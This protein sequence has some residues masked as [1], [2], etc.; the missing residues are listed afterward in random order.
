[1]ITDFEYQAL[2]DKTG[3]IPLYSV[4]GACGYFGA[5]QYVENEG[6][7]DA[8]DVIKF[9]DS[10]KHFVVH[11]SGNSMLPQIKDGNLCIFESYRG[12]DLH[13]INRKIVLCQYD[14]VDPAYHGTYT[15][16]VLEHP[17]SMAGN[18]KGLF[19]DE[20]HLVPLNKEYNNIIIN[21]S[22][23]ESFKIVGFLVGVI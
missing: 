21:L 19:E 8:R 17:F 20:V 18:H 16:K 3:Y 15:I 14:G 13:E 12:N 9:P 22:R 5:G 10:K 2:E 6:W 11:A 23:D 4:A 1:M 7:I